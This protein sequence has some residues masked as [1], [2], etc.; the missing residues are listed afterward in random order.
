MAYVG[1]MPTPDF[2]PVADVARLLKKDVRTVHRMIE[3][4][5]LEAV[6]AH[7]GIRAPY[8]VSRTSVD[9]ALS[10]AA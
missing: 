7:E 1:Q 2:L 9:A 10:S 6:K 4:G 3:R 5:E 8:L